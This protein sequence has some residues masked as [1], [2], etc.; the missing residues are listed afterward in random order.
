MGGIEVG[1]GLRG[2]LMRRAAPRAHE[3]VGQASPP[4]AAIGPSTIS[5]NVLADANAASAIRAICSIA[6]LGFMGGSGVS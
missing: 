1:F 6:D 2:Q 5:A 4:L 3:Q